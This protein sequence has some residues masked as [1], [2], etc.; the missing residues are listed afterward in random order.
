MNYPDVARKYGTDYGT[1]YGTNCG[2]NCRKYCVGNWGEYCGR[3]AGRMEDN[4]GNPAEIRVK[5][6]IGD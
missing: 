1:N 3:I 4:F 2:E 5:K 6:V